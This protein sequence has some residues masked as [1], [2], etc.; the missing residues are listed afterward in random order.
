MT[1][2]CRIRGELNTTLGKAGGEGANLLLVGP[3]THTERHNYWSSTT[4]TALMEPATLDTK[5]GIYR[6]R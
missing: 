3:T 2:Q 4:C 1:Y 6:R 5:A